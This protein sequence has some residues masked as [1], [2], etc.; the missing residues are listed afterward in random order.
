M[1]EKDEMNKKDDILFKSSKE[2]LNNLEENKK[3]IH[4]NNFKNMNEK[5]EMNNKDDIEFIHLI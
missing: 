3:N 2:I 5:D 1:N 4:Q